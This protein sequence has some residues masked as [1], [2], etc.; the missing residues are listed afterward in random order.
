M[1]D[2][3]AKN[4]QKDIIDN[5]PRLG[6]EDSFDFS[7]HPGVPCFNMCCRDITIVLT[8]YDILR[9]KNRL[10][11]SSEEFVAK[12]ALSPP[13]DGQQRIPIIIL[14]MQD[15]EEKTCPFLGENGCSV[16]E[17]RP[18]ACR[19]YPVGVASQRTE[20]NPDGQEFYFLL[21]ETEK[22]KGHDSG[23]PITVKQFME[24]QEVEKHEAMNEGFK[25]LTLHPMFE[26]DQLL[27]PQQV[28]MFF[29]AC[30][31]LD[32]F[33]RFLFNSKFFDIMILPD[34]G[35]KER[36]RDDE[37]ELLKFGFEWLRYSLFGEG[38]IR[39]RPEVIAA[40]HEEIKKDVDSRI[41]SDEKE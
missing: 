26:T 17:D 36:I 6:L 24:N 37:E 35:V 15:N 23:N 13:I 40:K 27:P 38:D 39:V 32:M 7:C 29:M 10:G 21:K 11:I 18:W 31:N 5:Y 9:L 34:E 30:Y 2:N 20:E 4:I 14:R 28:Q 1:T 25:R 3:A 12:Y 41:D 22:C 33:K 16:Y 8:P 19:M